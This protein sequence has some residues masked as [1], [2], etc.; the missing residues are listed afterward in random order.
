MTS[1]I[2]TLSP[3]TL[4]GQV[5]QVALIDPGGHTYGRTTGTCRPIVLIGAMV[6]LIAALREHSS[7]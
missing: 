7:N 3:M 6:H 4:S 5:D 2:Q 1:P